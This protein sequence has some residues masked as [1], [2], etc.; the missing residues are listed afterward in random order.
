MGN[1]ITHVFAQNGFK[2]R[3]IDVNPA[4]VE[5]AMQTISKNFDRQIGKEQLR[6]SKRNLR[7]QTS[8]Q[9][10]NWGRVKDCQLVVEAA[11]E[12]VDLKLKIFKQLDELVSDATIL[13]EYL[14]HFHN[15]NCVCYPQ[16]SDGDRD[17]FHESCTRDKIG[18]DHQWLRHQERS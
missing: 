4:Q 10:L 6:K 12:N 14:F 13:A 18:R 9:K 3:L 7:S 8:N 1:G 11:T 2:V 17:A 15:K 5:K 16:A